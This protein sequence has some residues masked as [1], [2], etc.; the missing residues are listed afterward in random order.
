MSYELWALL[1]I[2][3]CCVGKV[4]LS[5]VEGELMVWLRPLRSWS[6]NI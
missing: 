4:S 3:V 2:D 1:R 6:F 5:G